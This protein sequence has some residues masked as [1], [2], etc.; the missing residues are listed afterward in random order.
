LIDRF[1]MTNRTHVR[2]WRASG[3]V[4]TTY[5]RALSRL[6]LPLF[7]ILTGGMTG[8]ASPEDGRLR[9]DG[10]GADGGNYER[11][12]IHAPSKLDGTKPSMSVYSHAEEPS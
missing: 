5:S 2:G 3:P 4:R 9:G 12:P 7:L 10:P 6:L 8:C 1:K 11:K